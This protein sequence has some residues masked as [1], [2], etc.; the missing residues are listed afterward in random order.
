MNASTATAVF[1]PSR[2][3]NS[4]NGSITASRSVCGASSESL[5]SRITREVTTPT[6]MKPPVIQ[7]TEDHGSQSD[8]ISA[9]DP[10]TSEDR[11]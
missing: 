9:S 10:G 7:N 3:K 1:Q 5:T 11:R 6:P 4:R 2:A 8:R